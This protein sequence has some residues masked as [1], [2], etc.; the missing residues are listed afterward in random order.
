MS[1][2]VY[3]TRRGDPFDDAGPPITRDEWLDL[4]AKDADLSVEEPPDP[5]PGYKDAIHVAWKN[6][7]GGYAAWFVLFNG[8]V[9]VKGIDDALLGKLRAFATGLDARIVSELGEEFS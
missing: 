5:F 2:Y 9:E 4:V 8:N 6:Y 3:V 7:L 1:I